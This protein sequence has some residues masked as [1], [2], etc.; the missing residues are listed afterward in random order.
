MAVA[1]DADGNPDAATTQL[2]TDLGLTG[3]NDSKKELLTKAHAAM[4]STDK[5]DA[6]A[7][8]TAGSGWKL[9]NVRTA[10]ADDAWETTWAVP[11]GSSIDSWIGYD[12]VT[13][14]SKVYLWWVH[15]STYHTAVQDWH[16][17]WGGANSGTGAV[18]STNSGTDNLISDYTMAEAGT[19]K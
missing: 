11:T 16:L 7:S 9:P 12:T 10:I 3:G 5:T 8:T 6:G 13:T 19:D 17:F 2:Y 1:N 14:A 15:A 4:I 18:T